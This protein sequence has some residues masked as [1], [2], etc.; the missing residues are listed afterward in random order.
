MTLSKKYARKILSNIPPHF[1]F[2]VN[3]GPI[4]KSLAELYRELKAM[5]DDTFRYHA[6]NDKNDFS[7]WIKDCL[8]DNT[9]A[10]AL[11]KTKNRSKAVDVVRAR[12][13][14]LKRLA[15]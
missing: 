11:R 13:K 12:L 14:Y 15:G 1:S 3:N 10:D 8:G 4:I 9:L 6:N 5:N 2:W 7:N